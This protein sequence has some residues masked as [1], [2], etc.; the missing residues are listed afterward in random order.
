LEQNNRDIEGRD[1]DTD[2]IYYANGNNRARHIYDSDN[3]YRS[4]DLYDKD[5]D[6]QDD[7]NDK[8]D[9]DDNEILN[10]AGSNLSQADPKITA[11]EARWPRNLCRRRISVNTVD[12]NSI[13]PGHIS[14]IH[15]IEPFYLGRM[16]IIYF[17]CG[18]AYFE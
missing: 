6:K 12:N 15:E 2:N 13:P 3:D 4:Q 18:I 10:S 14:R 8:D 9:F 11:R 7:E 16:D 17:N 5:E 1:S